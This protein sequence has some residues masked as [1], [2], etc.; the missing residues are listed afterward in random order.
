MRGGEESLAGEGAA[1]LAAL[2]EQRE[3]RAQ[4]AGTEAARLRDAEEDVFP[5]L[6]SQ[7]LVDIDRP[8]FRKDIRHR[9]AE[10]ILDYGVGLGEMPHIGVEGP[11]ERRV[12]LRKLRKH[13]VP[14]AVAM[15][16]V[17]G[18]GPVLPILYAVGLGIRLD[19]GPRHRQERPEKPDLPSRQEGFG[20]HSGDASEACATQ[21]VQDEGLGIVVGVMRHRHGVEAVLGCDALEPAIA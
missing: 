7:E 6:E 15:R 13:F 3:R 11:D 19:F 16:V 1:A 10:I 14:D 17:L 8:V 4:G 2:C 12:D 5:V 21:E 18:V 20:G 9:F